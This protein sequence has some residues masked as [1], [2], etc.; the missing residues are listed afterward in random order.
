MGRE[1]AGK[2]A[3][4]PHDIAVLY[5]TNAQ[6]RV[7]EEEFGRYAIAYQV[8][9]GTR[10]YERAEVKDALAYLAVIDNPA[11]E[12]RLLRIVNMPR[13]GPRPDHDGAPADRSADA[14]RDIVER[15]RARRRRTR[16]DHRGGRLARRA[17]RR[18]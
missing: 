16:A 9:G 11:D 15:D 12:Q 4:A 8:V 2:A 18:W 10:F 5:R 7:L 1:G 13:R 14:R 6:S 3:L 17:S